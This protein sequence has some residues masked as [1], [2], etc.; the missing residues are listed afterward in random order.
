MQ[1]RRNLGLE[2]ADE[3]KIIAGPY[4]LYVGTSSALHMVIGKSMLRSITTTTNTSFS[5]SF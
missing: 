1:Q 2:N 5:S 3:R 4:N